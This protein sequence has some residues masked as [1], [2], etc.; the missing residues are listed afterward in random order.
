MERSLMKP[1]KEKV[2]NT[3]CR[4]IVKESN[5]TKEYLSSIKEYQP[6]IIKGYTYAF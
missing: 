4:R 5:Q 6:E 1:T 3:S 2:K